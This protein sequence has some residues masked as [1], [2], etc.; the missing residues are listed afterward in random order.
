MITGASTHNQRIERLWR[1]SRCCV[2]QLFYCLFYHL[3]SYDLLDPTNEMHIYALH[4][5]YL[6][7]INNALTAFQESWN[8]HSIRTEHNR[9]PHQLFIGG[10]LRLQRS[11]LVALDFFQQVDSQYGTEEE[12]LLAA[13]DGNVNVPQCCFEL[14]ESHHTEL[15]QQVDPETTSNCYGIDLY[16]QALQFIFQTVADNPEIYGELV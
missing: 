9:T 13:E 1:D 15:R 16:Q 5:I 2:T 3:E 11:G 12:G 6:S 4:Y 7:R 14:N 8:N 10:S